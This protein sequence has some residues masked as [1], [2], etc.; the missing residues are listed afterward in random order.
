MYNS[1]KS[2]LRALLIAALLVM[3]SMGVTAQPDRTRR[4]RFERGRTSKVIRDS[5]IRGTRDRYLVGARRGQ[6]LMVHI[7]SLEENAVFDVYPRG[8]DEPLNGAQ[9]TTDW[10][11]ELPRTGDYVIVVGGTRGNA[12]YTLEVKIR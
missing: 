2:R 5:V 11:G 10:G 4:I 9:E 12:S 6:T 7:T 1:S 8:S 3:S